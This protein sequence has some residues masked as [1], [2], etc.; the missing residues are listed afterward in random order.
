[1]LPASRSAQGFEGRQLQIQLRH[2]GDELIES[3]SSVGGYHLA[4]GVAAAVNGY[5]VAA[6]EQVEPETAPGGLI[7]EVKWVGGDHRKSTV[8][9]GSLP[10]RDDFLITASNAQQLWL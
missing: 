9:R 6:I 7:P 8:N 5:H 2:S 1:M 4:F 10:H 3:A